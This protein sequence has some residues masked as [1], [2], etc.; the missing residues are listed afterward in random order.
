VQVSASVFANALAPAGVLARGTGLDTT[1]PTYYAATLTRGVDIKLLRVVNGVT[2]TLGQ[3][4]S[5]TYLSNQWL[6]GSLRTSG[7]NVQVFVQRTDT[8]QYLAADGHWQSI[9][10]AA[11]NVTDSAIKGSGQAG[12]VKTADVTGTVYLDNFSVFSAGSSTSSG[13]GGGSS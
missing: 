6:Q 9:A 3:V 1:T 5:T 11:V 10:V 13:S 7:T 2:T 4:A 12:V 8:N